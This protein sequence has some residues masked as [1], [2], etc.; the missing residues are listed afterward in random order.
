MAARR[1][2]H[3]GCGVPV[4]DQWKTCRRSQKKLGVVFIWSRR[5]EERGACWL[6]D[7]AL[8]FKSFI[9]VL[10]RALFKFRLQSLAAR[11]SSDSPRLKAFAVLPPRFSSTL[12]RCLPLA[13]FWLQASS[14]RTFFAVQVRLRLFML[15]SPR[16][17][18][19][20]YLL[21]LEKIDLDQITLFD[22]HSR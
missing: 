10:G 22:P 16:S 1:H 4:E 13:S 12:V 2:T 15:W 20:L 17:S 19:T 11:V 3:T 6:V 5:A 9:T 14:I 21:L 7:T 18:K 8:S